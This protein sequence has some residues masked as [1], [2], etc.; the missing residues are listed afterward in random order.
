MQKLGILASLVLIGAALVGPMGFVVAQEA[1]QTATNATSTDATNATKTTPTQTVQ[2]PQK[3]LTMEE[4]IKKELAERKAKL[5]AKL[6]EQ[7]KKI[8]ERSLKKAQT[9][10]NLNEERLKKLEAE[11]KRQTTVKEQKAKLQEQMSK[12]KS[13]FEEQMNKKIGTLE[14]RTSAAKA[15]FDKMMADKLA[16]FNAK[17]KLKSKTV[18]PIEPAPPQTK[19]PAQ[20]TGSNSTRSNSQ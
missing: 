10:D 3:E 4:K 2:K 9:W 15:K 8:K 6:D 18:A 12:K 13:K 7:V 19:E 20:N 5:E 14:E 11:G 16:K 17:V 1:T